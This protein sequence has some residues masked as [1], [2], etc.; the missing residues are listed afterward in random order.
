MAAETTVSFRSAML[1]IARWLTSVRR[2]PRFEGTASKTCETTHRFHAAS[3]N[4]L[5]P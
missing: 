1:A 4:S 3:G 2:R 5:T